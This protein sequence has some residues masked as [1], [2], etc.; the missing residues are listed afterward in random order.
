MIQKDKLK[1]AIIFDLDGTLWQGVIGEDII[2]PNKELLE[3]IVLFAN[4]GVIIGICSKNNESDVDSLI[5]DELRLDRYISVK[6]INWK[7]KV[8][9]LKEIAEELNIGL[10]AIVFV[11]DSDFELNLIKEKLPEILTIHPNELM[12]T[13]I[14]WFD[15]SGDFTKTQQYKDNLNRTRT[16]EQFINID[17]YLHSLDMV[18]KIRINETSQIPRI[19]ELTQKTNQFNLTT[20]RYTEE[21]IKQIM[22]WGSVFTLS[23][24]DRFGD[25]GLTGV[26][27]IRGNSIDTFLLSCRILGRGIEYAFMDWIIENRQEKRWDGLL[28]KYIPTTKNKQIESFYP[29]LGFVYQGEYNGTLTYSLLLS[30]YKPKGAKYF[31]YE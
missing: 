24:R 25:N 29:K 19:A 13:V 14:E 23:V 1:K 10:D 28:G 8:S 21:E 26:C 12:R 6:R 18:L 11:D 27:I 31:R 7:D 3:N 4:R 20:I 5:K 9:N 16:Q 30:D 2:I 22:V 15:L 17:D